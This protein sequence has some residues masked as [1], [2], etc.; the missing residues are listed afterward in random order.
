MAGIGSDE[1]VCIAAEWKV[2]VLVY[3]CAGIAGKA[4]MGLRDGNVR[5]CEGTVRQ[6]MEMKLYDKKEACC[7]CGACVDV[8]PVGAIRMV[9]DDEGFRYPQVDEEKCVQCKRCEQ[10]CPMKH[11]DPGSG[12]NLYFGVQAKDDRIRYD[13]SSGGMFPLLA[14]W[15]FARQGVVYGAA[16]N[17]DMEVVHK[18]ARDLEELEAL[19]QT[20]YVQSNLDGIYRDIQAQLKEDRWVLF[21]GTPCQVRGLRLFLGKEYTKLIIADLICYGAPSPGVWADYVKHLERKNGGKITEFHFRDKRGRDNGHTRAYVTGG[22]EQAGPL[23][24]DVYSRMYFANDIIRPSCHACGYC[25][26]DR[27]S[28]FTLG[29]FWGIEKV[30][31]DVE[32]GMGTSVVILHT[33]KAREIWEQVKVNLLWFACGR[34]DVL[35]PRLQSPTEA[36]KGRGWFMFFYKLL[37]F[38]VVKSF[39]VGIMSWKAFWGRL[40]GK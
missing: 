40:L 17:E 10:V 1:G 16:F 5:E 30:R 7:G 25:T 20:K 24:S 13:S 18:A 21:V 23:N 34:E 11:R 14:A 37:P 9:M 35:Q 19:K 3:G 29:D 33:G 38:S 15:V 4:A 8:C 36:A 31:P 28:D 32:D 26:P 6:E 22:R 39:F 2:R 12:E 27:N